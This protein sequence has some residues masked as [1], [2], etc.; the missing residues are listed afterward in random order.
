MASALT[1]TPKP[2]QADQPEQKPATSASLVVWSA[3]VLPF[4]LF[5]YFRL[6]GE[7]TSLRREIVFPLQTLSSR[8]GD[9]T[10]SVYL[11]KTGASERFDTVDKRLLVFEGMIKEELERTR[12]ERQTFALQQAE[13]D[14]ALVN[15]LAGHVL[16]NR[17]KSVPPEV[18]KELGAT[19]GHIAAFMDEIE[20]KASLRLGHLDGLERKGNDPRGIEKARAV[21]LKLQSLADSKTGN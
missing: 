16:M 15:R 20:L 7:I 18:L 8:V 10:K 6:R 3:L 1:A 12:L 19:I 11:L 5:S 14:A 4:A 9:T 13:R 21:A 2:P 17:N